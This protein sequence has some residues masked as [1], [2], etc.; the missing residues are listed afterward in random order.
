MI[1][2][3]ELERRIQRFINEKL[4]DPSEDL[5][6]HADSLLFEDG[7]INSLRVL[8][9]IAFVE[10]ALGRKIPDRAIKLANFRSIRAIVR[11]CLPEP[12][13][14]LEWSP[15]GR[16]QRLAE[17]RTDRYRFAS[18]IEGLRARGDLVSFGPGRVGLGGAVLDLV[19]FFD[20]IA[21][22]WARDLGAAER[23]YPALVALETLGRAG[24][25]ES[26][27]QHLTVAAPLENDPELRARISAGARALRRAD[28]ASPSHALAPAV[29]YHC[30][31]ELEGRT[32]GAGPVVL[33]AQGRCFRHEDGDFATLE[34]LWDFTMREIVVAGAR[35]EVEEVRRT[36]VRRAAE[37]LSALDLDG[38]IEPATDPFFTRAT[39]AK[40]L[41][42]RLGA[43]K[44][45][46]RV[47]L[48]ADGRS[49]A[50]ASFNHHQDHFGR[51]FDVRLATGR[52][53]HSGC[54]AFG[55]ERWALAFL[56]Q[57]GLDDSLWPAEV[58]AWRD[59]GGL[60]GQPA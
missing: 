22:R 55:L 51:A 10:S 53:V 2:R 49:L 36:L 24:Y 17:H 13:A 40:R 8:D 1:T 41:V 18:P 7:Y 27:P 9:L 25:L 39:D 3:D 4:L 11:A 44:Y 5:A 60:C 23:Q 45:E 43:L 26:F 38:C 50:V 57:H 35:D 29:C 31:A 30:W 6:V 32:L 20:S 37:L 58:R 14:A 21:F 42:Q 15:F 28:V 34:R 19:R 12:E 33:T 59:T 52:P 16:P 48:D 56:T 47:T 46:L 54:V